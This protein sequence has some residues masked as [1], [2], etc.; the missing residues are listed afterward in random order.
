MP[1]NVET[2]L[3][4]LKSSNVYKRRLA[5]TE[6]G[7]LVNSD[8]RIVSVLIDLKESDNDGGVRSLAAESLLAS[9]H[10]AV[11]KG[12]PDLMA[13]MTPVQ[14]DRTSSIE[15]GS[16]TSQ[17][18]EN[19]TRYKAQTFTQGRNEF[20]CVS[21]LSKPAVRYVEFYQIIGLIIVL[22]RRSIKGK[23]CKDC[24]EKH[25]WSYTGTTLL[26]GWWGIF[27]FLLTPF[28]LIN[29][30]VRYL[31]FGGGAVALVS[32]VVPVCLVFPFIFG[33]ITPSSSSPAGEL[34]YSSSSPL[35]RITKTPAPN[36]NLQ[37]TKVSSNINCVLWSKVTLEDVGK[38]MC[39][40]G[41]VK[42]AYVGND[43]YYYI[44]FSKDLRDF[45][46]LSYDAYFPEV[47]KDSC[48]Q[49]TKKIEK[50][51]NSPVIVIKNSDELYIC[52]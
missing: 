16:S 35:P 17:R 25:F 9:A 15:Q 50:L 39:V 38:K 29:N 12:R 27:S 7:K 32:L 44:T 10:Q 33:M 13:K 24:I 18:D 46:L 45:Y 48:V 14:I 42:N 52:D 19:I 51:G 31:G 43:N 5:V 41:K 11:L 4:Y 40:Y 22:F 8:A 1:A 20:I 21:C 3:D 26:M 47:A 30:F 23:L 6:L 2:L 49:I 36:H 28:V 37:P 34:S